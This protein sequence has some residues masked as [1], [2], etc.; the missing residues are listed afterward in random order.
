M[1]SQ[2]FFDSF[3]HDLQQARHRSGLI[4]VTIFG[5]S[6][7]AFIPLVLGVEK[8]SKQPILASWR[9]P[10]WQPMQHPDRAAWNVPV[11]AADA[12]SNADARLWHNGPFYRPFRASI[13]LSL[14]RCSLAWPSTSALPLPSQSTQLLACG[15][16]L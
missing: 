16:A 2:M 13:S 6:Q 7:T 8:H 12:K 14:R 1:F 4:I 3:C 9:V 10:F 15:T 5:L 11:F